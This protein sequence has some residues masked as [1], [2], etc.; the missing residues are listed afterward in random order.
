MSWVR[1]LFSQGLYGAHLFH[2]DI[3]SAF[4]VLDV[5]LGNHDSVNPGR[6]WEG[7]PQHVCDRTGIKHAVDQIEQA[8]ESR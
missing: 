7:F 4:R 2:V 6:E 3:I 8:T 1:Q 5:L